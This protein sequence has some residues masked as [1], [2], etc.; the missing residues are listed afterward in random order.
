MEA[1][2]QTDCPRIRL[3]HLLVGLP[4]LLVS[5]LDHPGH[6]CPFHT[7]VFCSAQDSTVSIRFRMRGLGGGKHWAYS[8]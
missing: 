8:S 1:A 6:P 4:A 7:Y 3:Q 5:F 2:E